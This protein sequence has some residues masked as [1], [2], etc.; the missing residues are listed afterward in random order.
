LLFDEDLHELHAGRAELFGGLSLLLQRKL[1]Y[2]STQR[3]H[4][5]NSVLV[6]HLGQSGGIGSQ[7]FRYIT[8]IIQ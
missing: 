8:A 5:S 4:G 1:A 2:G 3:E 6:Q 7:E